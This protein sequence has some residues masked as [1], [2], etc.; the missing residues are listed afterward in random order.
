MTSTEQL[1]ST[2]KVPPSVI[3]LGWVSFLTDMASEMI[4][5]LIP[6][7]VVQT[8]GASPALLGLIDGVAEG[9][10][11]CLRWLGGALSDRTGKRKP[12]ILA[13]Y[14]LSAISKPIMGIAAVIGGWPVFMA[15]RC[16]DRLGK[17]LRTG[18]RDAL[19]ADSTDP[20]Y[21]GAAFGLHRAMDT[22]GAVI[23]PLVGWLILFVR[24]NIHLAWI[25]V[26]ALIPGL[27]SAGLVALA[28]RENRRPPGD[29]TP[30]PI[31]QKYPATFW[32]VLI[33]MGIFSLANSSDSFLILRSNEMGVSRR[34]V[35]LAFTLYNVVYALASAPFGSLSD[36]V[37][38]RPIIATGWFVYAAVYLGFGL[39]RGSSVPWILFAVYGIYQAMAEGV[40]KALV[41]DVVPSH[42]RAGAIG[43]IYTVAGFGQLFGSVLAGVTW[44][45]TVPG[46]PLRTPF[47]VAAAFSIVAGVLLL[48]MT[49]TSAGSFLDSKGLKR[50][51][52]R[53]G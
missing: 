36:R 14:S 49:G 17:S 25:F 48:F 28:V 2:S 39:A 5:P 22:A 15:G 9:I 27:A 43:L 10:S 51:Q 21:R 7:F 1:P 40:S 52:S 44:N 19:I 18:A 8:L 24:P 3:T 12:F 45:H 26:A 30:P 4:Y 20:V 13:G 37:G 31:F 6:V 53:R 32:P 29:G 16:F 38:R 33:V 41:S 47:A 35:I 46:T 42:Q 11:S 50:P 23:G 34:A